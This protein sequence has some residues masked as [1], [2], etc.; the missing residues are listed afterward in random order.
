MIQ[1]KLPSQIKTH[2]Y[3]KHSSPFMERY[4]S[5]WYFVNK[6]KVNKIRIFKSNLYPKNIL[7]LDK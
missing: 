1:D 7:R 6:T 3:P 5:F 4:M 2:H